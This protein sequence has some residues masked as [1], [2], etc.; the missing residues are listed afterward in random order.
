MRKIGIVKNHAIKPL[1]AIVAFCLPATIIPAQTPQATG[2]NPTGRSISAIGYQ[3]DRGSTMVDLNGTGLMP[4]VSG[5]A[6]VE[7][8]RAVTTVEAEIR[9]LTTPT[10]LGAEF[11]THVL[12][13]VSPEGG[14]VNLGEVL[15]DKSGNSKLKT[16]TQLRSFSLFVTV[17]PLPPCGN[18]AN[19]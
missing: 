3:V 8:K 18:R 10:R 15:F 19:C 5:Q 2:S 4:Q 14:A 6:K 16:T 9:G 17:E 13:A 1:L 11:L 7:A 12:W